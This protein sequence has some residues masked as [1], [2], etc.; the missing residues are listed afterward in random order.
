M[1]KCVYIACLRVYLC[2]RVIVRECV[3]GESYACVCVFACVCDGVCACVTH[4]YIYIYTHACVRVSSCVGLTVVQKKVSRF[5]LPSVGSASRT[6]HVWLQKQTHLSVPFSKLDGDGNPWVFNVCFQIFKIDFSHR[7]FCGQT[8]MVDNSI[9]S[10]NI[11][12]RR[13]VPDCK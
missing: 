10:C 9:L 12:V 13:F 2:A 1:R 3:L 5:F 6:T 11:L 8:L 7:R 4:V